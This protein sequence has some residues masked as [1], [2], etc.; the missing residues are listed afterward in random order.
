MT[1]KL[2]L[3]DQDL[4][5]SSFDMVNLEGVSFQ[6]ANLGHA[7]FEDIN[8]AGAT[9]NDINFSDVTFSAAQLGG[10]VFKQL[11]LPP[12]SP[13]KQRGITFEDADMNDSVFRDCN[14]QNARVEKCNTTGMT[15]D[16]V[17]VSDLLA[18]YAKS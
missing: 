15:I 9:F 14:L 18:A 2:T 5:G 10:T 1:E 11:G 16:G 17:L 7:K 4:S 6:N 13:E 3:R 12:G 8:L